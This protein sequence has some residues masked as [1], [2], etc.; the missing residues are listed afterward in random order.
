MNPGS[1]A[2]LFSDDSTAMRVTFKNKPI[3]NGYWRGLIL[4]Y[5]NGTI[6]RPVWYRL[7]NI[8]FLPD[9]ALNTSGDYEV[10][11]EPHQKKW[12]FYLDS[13][14]A[15]HPNLLF[16]PDYG[17]VTENKEPITQR[18]AYAL[19]VQATPYATLSPQEQAQNTQ[20]PKNTNPQLT[21]WAHEHYAQQQQ[22]PKAFIA[23]LKNYINQNPFWY[24]LTP[25]PLGSSKNQMDIFWFETQKGFCEHYASAVTVILRSVGIPARVLVGYQ[26]GEW[27]PLGH[28]LNIKHNNAHAWLEY[29][30]EG[31]GW[32]S[33]D[34]TSF[35]AEE[36]IEQ[37]IK[38]RLTN[39][40]NQSNF[41]DNLGLSWFSRTQLAFESARFFTE[42]WLLFYNQETQRNL[43]EKLGLAQWDSSQLLQAAIG[44]LLL[45]ILVTA[46]YYQWIHQRNQD[47]LLREY[48]LLQR[49]FRRFNVWISPSSTLKKQCD[50]LI[51]KAPKLTA[52]LTLFLYH[53]EQLRLH[54]QNPSHAKQNKQETIRLFKSLRNKLRQ[55]KPSTSKL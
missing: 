6:W 9:L 47:P 1:I 25:P 19:T 53:Y 42:R 45:F 31:V 33:F 50:S 20:L 36:R 18:F 27:N 4:N 2:D 55:H 21:T 35:I 39:Q 30:Q 22:D 26:G 43:L 51:Q 16:S 44:A 48:H 41:L 37:R 3:I 14:V 49:E 54:P 11:L 10:L 34:P 46:V 17:L 13:P 32:Q 38:D 15:S 52:T 8:R 5:Y 28:Y 24:T 40:L 7:D 23:F 12:L 29:W